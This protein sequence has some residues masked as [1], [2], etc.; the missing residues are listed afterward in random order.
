MCHYR[1]GIYKGIYC[2]SSCGRWK[3]KETLVPLLSDGS[4]PR[5]R[6]GQERSDV[7]TEKNPIWKGDVTIG[8]I[9]RRWELKFTSSLLPDL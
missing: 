5:L 1:L 6:R 3:G 4:Y 8:L 9:A 7:D 2:N